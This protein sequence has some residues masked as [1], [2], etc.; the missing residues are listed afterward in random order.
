MLN[1]TTPEPNFP[2]PDWLYQGQTVYVCYR[3]EN[4]WVGLPCKVA[5]A[6]GD[7]GRLVNEKYSYDRW[8]SRWDMRVKRT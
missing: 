6:C 3:Y 5:V 7:T 2:I 8:V 4:R 1:F